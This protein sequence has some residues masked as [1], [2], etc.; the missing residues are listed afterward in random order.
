MSMKTMKILLL[1]V[2][3]FPVV[4]QAAA[5]TASDTVMCRKTKGKCSF[6]LC[7]MFKRPKGTCYNGLAKCCRPFW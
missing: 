1:L 7:P 2:L 5:V 6:L 3:L 4:S